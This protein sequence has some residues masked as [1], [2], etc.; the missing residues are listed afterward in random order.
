MLSRDV[1]ARRQRLDA[2]STVEME[3]AESAD[4]KHR[5]AHESADA[6]VD[7][8][9]RMAACFERRGRVLLFGNGGSAADAQHIADEFVNRFRR[10]R[11]ALSALALS[12]NASDLTAIGNDRGFDVVFARQIEAHGRE[13]DIALALSTSGDSPNVI[14]GVEAARARGLETLALS[15]RG[16][17]KL[18]G[19]VD[20]A[21]VVPSKDTARIQEAHITIGHILCELVD[22]ALYPGALAT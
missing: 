8:G 11:P 6:I 18:A 10:E 17:G 22:Q 7:A 13:G 4:I 1:T 21:I 5:L 19:M 20:L 16:G 12:V 15:G 9:Q 14:A 2:R 3:L